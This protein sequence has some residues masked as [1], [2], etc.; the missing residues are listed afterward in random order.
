M[1]NLTLEMASNNTNTEGYSVEFFKI[2]DG[3]EAIVRFIEDSVEN[4]EL[5]SVHSLNL[6]SGFRMV[7]C[8]R[9]P[10]EPFEKCPL[11]ASGKDL[12]NRFYVKLVHYTRNPDGSISATPKIWDRP[13]SFAH[14]IKEYLGNYGPLSNIMCKIVRHGTGLET[15]YE[16]IPNLNPQ[17]YSESIYPK[18][19]MGAFATTKAL[20]TM[21]ID[22]PYNDVQY[23]AQ[24]N[25]LPQKET[26][27]VP[28]T[29]P[30]SVVPTATTTATMS[31]NTISQAETTP[32]WALDTPAGV[33]KP[34]RYY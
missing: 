31:P 3:E 28:P 7:S 25:S 15:K 9:S 4:F 21:V 2:N 1:A 14:T 20:G 32:P 19:A 8:L 34:T 23:I 33:Q 17:M 6:I 11:C 13:V 27:G 26:V 16:I 18:D 22:A 29:A 30:T 5:L 12:K 10:N 24:T